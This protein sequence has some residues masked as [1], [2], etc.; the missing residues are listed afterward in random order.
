MR[1]LTVEF[2]IFNLISA[3]NATEVPTT[4]RRVECLHN[5]FS[6][7]ALFYLDGLPI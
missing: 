4:T 2:K 6:L 3:Q 5:F 7:A 1:N